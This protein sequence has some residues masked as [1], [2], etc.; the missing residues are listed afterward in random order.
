MFVD[1]INNSPVSIK[2]L[3]IHLNVLIL[4][5]FIYFYLNGFASLYTVLLLIQNVI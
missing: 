2:L 3:F 4:I 1:F 5:L